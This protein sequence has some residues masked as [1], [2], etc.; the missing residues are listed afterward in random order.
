MKLIVN[1]DSIASGNE[2]FILAKKMIPVNRSILGM[3][4]VIITRDSGYFTPEIEKVIHY[5]T[6]LVPSKIGVFDLLSSP[7]FS[8]TSRHS[9]SDGIFQ[10]I[11]ARIIVATSIEENAAAAY[12][13]SAKVFVFQHRL[14]KL[15]MVDKLNTKSDHKLR[16]LNRVFWFA[17]IPKFVPHFRTVCR[18]FM[19][20]TM[21]TTRVST[22]Q[23]NGFGIIFELVQVHVSG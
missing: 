4:S 12:V 8:I 13:Y 9:N 17:S 21:N 7:S 3:I 19:I 22:N 6:F 1:L 15:E 23:A 5:F 16:R 18:T 14:I 2:I 10:I 20:H 11:M